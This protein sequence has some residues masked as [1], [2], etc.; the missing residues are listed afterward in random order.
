MLERTNALPLYV[1]AR[2]VLLARLEN[3]EYKVNEKIPSESELCKEFGISRVTLRSVLT[4]LVR[5]GKLY[6]IQGKGTFVAEPKITAD[7]ISYVGIR[8]QLEQQGYDVSTVV[9]SVDVIDCPRS[10]AKAMELEQGEPVYHI[11]RLRKV[12]GI[13]LSIHNSY[14]PVSR[15]PNL[16]N[17]DFCNVQLCNILSDNYDLRR[18]SVSETLESVVAR[19]DEAA[20]LNIGKGHPLLRLCDVISDK[21]GFVFEYSTV[22]FRGDKLLIRLRYEI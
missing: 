12:K 13:P 4:E 16:Q 19:E 3:E 6:R 17:N 7:T 5:D 11:Q 14:I 1:Q 20:L 21:N 2:N 10:V 9:L 8:E 18:S 15:C 22:V